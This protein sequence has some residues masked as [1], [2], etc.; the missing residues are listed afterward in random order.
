MYSKY[1]ELVLRK[2]EVTKDTTAVAY[3]VTELPTLWLETTHSAS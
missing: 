3:A 2:A 1:C